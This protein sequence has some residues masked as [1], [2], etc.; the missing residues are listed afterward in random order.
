MNLFDLIHSG[1]TIIGVLFC[2]TAVLKF[3]S[4]N[5]LL[6]IIATLSLSISISVATGGSLSS[7][8]ARTDHLAPLIV[9]LLSS[10]SLIVAK[11]AIFASFL[12]LKSVS[13]CLAII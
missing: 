5:G 3:A 2:L 6:S 9:G 1:C 8:I 11:I 4:I 7:S 10:L 12:A 13:P